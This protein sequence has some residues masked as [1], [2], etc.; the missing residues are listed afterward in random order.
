[1]DELTGNARRCIFIVIT[2]I[3]VLIGV[4]G[5]SAARAEGTDFGNPH[6]IATWSVPPMADGS[7]IGASR[8]FENQTVRQIAID[9]GARDAARRP[10]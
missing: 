1:M 3:L 4:T 2:S 7:A 8:S 10:Q 5:P 6:W 9:P